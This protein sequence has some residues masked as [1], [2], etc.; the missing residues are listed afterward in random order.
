MK[1]FLLAL[2]FCLLCVAQADDTPTCSSVALASVVRN[3]NLTICKTSV[4]FTALEAPPTATQFAVLCNTTACVGIMETI[5]ALNISDC[6]LPTGVGLKLMSEI[7]Y[8]TVEYCEEN[9]VEVVGGSDID[10]SAIDAGDSGSSG[11]ATAAGSTSITSSAVASSSLLRTVRNG[12]AFV[13]LA[14]FLA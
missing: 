7:V 4:D 13:L 12:L 9:G 10:D 11:S 2:L 14:A 1:Q 5:L 8:P 3:A 6:V